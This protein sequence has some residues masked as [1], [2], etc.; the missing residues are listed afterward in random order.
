M[1]SYKETS[2][3]HGRA[4]THSSYNSN[5]KP[6]WV[7]AWG[8]ELGHN[9][10]SNWELWT[11]VSYQEKESQ[12]FFFSK[13]VILS[14]SAMLKWKTTHLKSTNWSW[15]TFFKD[16]KLRRGLN[17]RRLNITKPLAKGL[18]KNGLFSRKK[19]EEEEEERKKRRRKRRRGRRIEKQQ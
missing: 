19:K 11:L 17:I 1:V 7:P 10:I 12:A 5:H 13:N 16:P 6:E 14:K 3:G 9:P 15:R 18:I 8:G 2:S 4:W